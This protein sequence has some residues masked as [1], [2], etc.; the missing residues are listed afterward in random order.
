MP[1]AMHLRP[2]FETV[3]FASVVLLLKRGLEMLVA[4]KFERHC[5]SKESF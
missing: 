3:F 4:G 2:I 1:V 5:E